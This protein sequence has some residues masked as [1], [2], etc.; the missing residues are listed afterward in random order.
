M[1]SADWF[2]QTLLQQRLLGQNRVSDDELEQTWGWE[3]ALR[4]VFPELNQ[5]FQQVA[6][7]S[8]SRNRPVR[9]QFGFTQPLR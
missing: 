8:I 6:S 1:Q 9:V 7:R 4:W 3:W 2:Y 5:A